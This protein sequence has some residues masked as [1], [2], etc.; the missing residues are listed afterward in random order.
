MRLD[1]K[2]KSPDHLYPLLSFLKMDHSFAND[3]LCFGA[4]SLRCFRHHCFGAYTLDR[5]S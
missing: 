3:A 1:R 4:D 5:L 2:M